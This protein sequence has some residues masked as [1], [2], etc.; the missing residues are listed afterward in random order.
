MFPPETF[1]RTNPNIMLFTSISERVI[2]PGIGFALI[3]LFLTF[4]FGRFYCGWICPLGSM[5]DLS[6]SLSKNNIRLSDKANGKVRKGKYFV[7][8]AILISAAVGVQVAWVLD[9]MAIMARFVSLNLIPTVTLGMEKLFTFL[10]RDLNMYEGGVQDLYHALRSSLLGVK[11]TYFSDSGMIFAVFLA[12]FVS[13]FF[14]SRLWCRMVC[15]LGGVY[16]VLGRFS[17]LERY[18]EGCTNCGNC[19]SNCRMGAINM[20]A[21]YVKSE[22]VLCMDCI[23][24]CPVHGTSFTWMP[25][26]NKVSQGAPTGKPGRGVSRKEFLFL[27]VSSLFALGFK[28]INKARNAAGRV[29]RPPGA[30]KEPDFVDRCIRCGNCMKV[31]PTNGLQPVMLQAGVEG[32]W[33]PQLVPEI[34]YCEYN[35]TLCGSVCPTG[36]IPRLSSER[37]KAMK[38]GIASVDR[39]ICIAWAY[40]SECIVCEEHC[41]VSDKAIKVVKEKIDGRTVLKPRV[42][43][44]LCIGCG[45]CQNKCPVRPARAIKVSPEGADRT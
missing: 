8:G 3:M 14:L 34:G 19:I 2:L 1:F 30:L 37:K 24:D 21:G 11:V 22:C 4:V 27:V 17:L 13:A 36:A 28:G 15:P 32:I 25:G 6:G 39:S 38:L 35:C 9:P 40:G 44:E 41:P 12:I 23:Y 43:P 16:S 10:I 42:D 18:V 31:C 5:I 45:I 20:D 33:T 26:R 7:L 29:I